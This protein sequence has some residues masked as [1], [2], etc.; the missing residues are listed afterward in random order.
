VALLSEPQVLYQLLSLLSVDL[1]SSQTTHM[2]HHPNDNIT[3]MMCKETDC[4]PRLFVTLYF[5]HDDNTT[6]GDQRKVE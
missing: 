1:A 6:L 3:M 4:V 2:L 5:K